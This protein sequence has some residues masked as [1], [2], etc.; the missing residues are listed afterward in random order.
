M[1]MKSTLRVYNA[2]NVQSVPGVTKGQ[3]QQQLLGN[4]EH[5][6]ERLIV[7]LVSFVPGTYEKLHWHLIEAFYYVISGSAVMK[8]I[9]GKTHEIKAGSVVY[10]PPGIAGSHSWE[11]KEQLQLMSI[12]ATADSE[13]TIQF[14][15]DPQTMESSVSLDHLLNRQA[16]NPK[17]SAY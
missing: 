3:T 12:R 14:D 7:R 15:V 10:A 8:D 4:A 6:S 13:K 2:A 1:E 17:K 16:V 5:P 9:E 11:I